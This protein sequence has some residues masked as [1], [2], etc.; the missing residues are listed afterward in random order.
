MLAEILLQMAAEVFGWMLEEDLGATGLV[1]EP[2]VDSFNFPTHFPCKEEV[3]TII[4]AEGSFNLEKI[5]IF[6]VN[7]DGTANNDND[8]DFGNSHSIK[9][10]TNTVRAFSE[11]MLANY[12]GTSILD[13]LFERY[14][15][16]IARR[17]TNANSYFLSHVFAL[18]RK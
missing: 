5:E 14:E 4:Q 6:E 17:L 7:W 1:E 13:E 11:P 8:C 12:F 9:I 3:V 16:H 2:K 18:K 15:K 10:I